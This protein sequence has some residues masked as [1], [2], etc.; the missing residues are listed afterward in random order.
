MAYKLNLGDPMPR[1]QAKDH[2]GEVYF[3][4]DLSGVPLILYFYPKDDTP[5]CT[6]QACSF[7]D[8]FARIKENGALILGVSPDEGS[9]HQKFSDKYQ[10]N[11]PLLIDAQREICKMF[12][13]LREKEV[14]GKKKMSLERTTFL[15]DRLGKIA[16]IERPVA[17]EGHVDRVIEA[18]KKLG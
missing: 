17:V 15:I 4:D 14:E 8:N 2:Q 7:R 5:G 10:L 12:D 11:F 3:S 1:F 16:W 6:K 18:L 9:S 13:V